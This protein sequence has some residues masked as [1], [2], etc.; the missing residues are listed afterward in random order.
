VVSQGLYVLYAISL[1]CVFTK[2]H[3]AYIFFPERY[4]ESYSVID[5][6]WLGSG[7]VWEAYNRPIYKYN[8]GS[9]NPSFDGTDDL[10][11]LMYSGSR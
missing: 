10:L 1:V 5:M 4:N 11:L 6:D 8:L 2:C 9:G 7:Q 3:V